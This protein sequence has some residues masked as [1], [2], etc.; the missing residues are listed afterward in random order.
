[1]TEPTESDEASA[2]EATR[3][4]L[5]GLVLGAVLV[6]FGAF[7][8]WAGGQFAEQGLFDHQHNQLFDAD[9]NRVIYN[10]TSFDG[11]YQRS[12]THPLHVFLIAPVGH[13]LARLLGSPADAVLAL[14]ALFAAGVLWNVNHI[15]RQQLRLGRADR[16]LLL[17]L[18]GASASQVTFT[19]V[20]DTHILSALGLSGMARSLGSMDLGEL[21]QARGAVPW[22]R[23]GGAKLLAWGVFAVGMLVTNVLLVA[24][25]CYLL[26][27]RREKERWRA[28][29]S[30]GLGAASVL[31]V[32]GGLHVVQSLAW[33]PP[34]S[35]AE[36]ARDDAALQALAVE[37]A[38]SSRELHQRQ[39]FSIAQELARAP[40]SA[41]VAA[42]GADPD[43]EDALAIQ[44][45]SLSKVVAQAQERIRYNATYLTPVRELPTRAVHVV[46]AIFVN[47]FYA[48]SFRV[49]HRWYPPVTVATNATFEPWCTDHRLWG[50]LGAVAW[51]SWFALAGMVGGRRERTRGGAEVLLKF[52]LMVVLAYAGIVWVYGDELFLYSPNWAFAVVLVAACWYARVGEARR[53]R[54]WLRAALA[55]AVV[56]LCVNTASHVG[57]LF[58]LFL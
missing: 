1:M 49:T 21:R 5:E 13:V 57:A 52:S 6:V 28:V 48:P 23:G 8:W 31:V 14:T 20:P 10:S 4:R 25:L 47:T 18:L 19:M 37:Q 43:P 29:G 44:P 45:A 38:R 56:A 34:R 55:V 42:S 27:P 46:T 54:P 32:V 35:E 39:Y 11:P 9:P 51:L 33:P 7:A 2:R 36:A 40:A 3:S 24:W 30:A 41:S 53:M 12:R 58:A 50:G 15:L 17:G 26:W 16:V 22:L